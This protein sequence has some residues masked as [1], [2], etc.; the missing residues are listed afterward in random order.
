MKTKLRINKSITLCGSVLFLQ[1]IWMQ[2]SLIC[3]NIPDV[4]YK[5]LYYMKYFGA[6]LLLMY[7]MSRRYIYPELKLKQ[8][9]YVKMMLPYMLLVCFVELLAFIY[10]PIVAMYGIRYWSRFLAYFLDKLCIFIE[11]SCIYLLCGRDSIKCVTSVLV[12]DGMV[13]MVIACFKAGISSALIGITSLLSMS[14]GRSSVLEVHEL[15]FCLGIIIIYYVFFRKEKL[16]KKLPM[17]LI[18]IFLFMV[19][20]KRIGYAGIFAGGIFA[21]IVHRK[22]INKKCL[23][24]VG[25]IGVIICFGYIMLL[26]NG[27]IMAYL[28]MN[29]INSMGRD[30]LN[31]YFTSLATF[32][33]DFF[34]W[35][36]G[37]VSKAIENM[38]RADV[39]SMVNVGGLHN[40]ILKVYLECGFVCSMLWF[41]Y[42]LIYLPVKMFESY[43]RNTATLFVAVLIYAFI[44]YLTDNT[45]NYFIFQVLL[46]LLPLAAEEQNREELMLRDMVKKS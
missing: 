42:H 35:G 9:R 36:F 12:F 40:D 11:V 8:R 38:S 26:F 45:E 21:F 25:G 20:D 2:T 33:I 14:E 16:R 22:G 31:S 24:V 19:G 34:G 23:F 6:M 7:T 18:L 10:S 32:D 44:T 37:G 5:I 43:N 1:L 30:V 39:G 17:I 41:C 13:L 15:S 46:F 27:E 3:P 29:G 4:L 28:A